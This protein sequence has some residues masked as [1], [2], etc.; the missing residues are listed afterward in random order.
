MSDKNFSD[1]QLKQ[2]V[3]KS[4][5]IKEVCRKLGFSTNNIKVINRIQEL[6]I[7]ISHFNPYQKSNVSEE[8]WKNAA[9]TSHSL[10]EMAEKLGYSSTAYYRVKY[11]INQLNLDISHFKRQNIKQKPIVSKY[12]KYI[13]QK[14]SV[15]N[16]KD[17]NSIIYKT[18]RQLKFHC[19]C[20]NG[21]IQDISCKKLFDKNIPICKQCIDYNKK[22]IPQTKW[23]S[24]EQ[25]AKK[26]GLEFS[27]D[28]KTAEN[29]L[30]K[31]DFCCA[32]SGAKIKFGRNNFVEENTASLDRID[33]NKGYI[34][35]NIQWVHKVVNVMKQ[36][37]SDKELISWCKLIVEKNK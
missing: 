17:I 4:L 21:H 16:I 13:G 2:A 19:I 18:G 22:Y 7:D 31:Q 26:R 15:W 34:E 12:Y 24:I 6:K 33:S 28:K 14:I 32:I 37:L 8:E 11:Q 29:L 35:G 27:I 9:Q 20:D 1:F 36:C 23:Y 10:K 30:I 3:K 25:G 5:S